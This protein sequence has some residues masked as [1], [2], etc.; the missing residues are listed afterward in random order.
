MNTQEALTKL[1]ISSLRGR[2]SDAIDAI[3][4]GR[5]VLYLFPTGTGKTVVYETAALCCEHASIVVSPLVGLLQQ[6]AERLAECGIVVMQ[7]WDGKL[8]LKGE[9][10]VKVVYTTP[11][12]LAP[13]TALRTHLQ[14]NHISVKRLVVDEAHLVVQW[15]SFRCA[16]CS[17]VYLFE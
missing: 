9:G 5:D 3:N 14:S 15:E 8:L 10:N 6:Q 13:G 12:Q 16:H 17:F 4:S 2:Q 1:G 11:E 7:A